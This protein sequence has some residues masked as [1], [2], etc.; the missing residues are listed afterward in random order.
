[1]TS[2]HHNLYS[3]KG[4]HG[5]KPC[6]RGGAHIGRQATLAAIALF[7]A[8]LGLLFLPFFKKCQYCSHNTWWNQ[9]A[10]PGTQNG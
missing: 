5:C 8:G 7:T 9:H 3:Q 10:R 2:Q 1:M 6:E 4:C